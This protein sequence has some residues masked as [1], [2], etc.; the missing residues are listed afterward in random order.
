MKV[1][2]ACSWGE[3]PSSLL[4]KYKKQ[5][6]GNSGVWGSITSTE[7]HFDSDFIVFLGSRPRTIPGSNKIIQFRREPDFIE[8]YCSIPNSYKN[9]DYD[10]LGYHVSTWFLEKSFDELEEM[11]YP[12][13]IKKISSIS[14]SKWE[15]RNSILNLVSK[16]MLPGQID[17][18]GRN[19][20]SV[21]GTLNYKGQLNYNKKCKF[22]GL[23]GY[24]YSIAIENSSQKNYFTE[25]IIDCFLS[26]T[27]PIYWGC[28]NISNYFPEDS[29]YL[30]KD[31]EDVLEI[32]KRPVEKRNIKALREARDLVLNKYN[33]W[34]TI[35]HIIS[36]DYR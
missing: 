11:E 31:P 1:S 18:Y 30:I 6:P 14:S 21:V 15:H 22:N 13:K 35:S 33:L 17:F 4:K 28:P 23:A 8:K 10:N 12:K 32:I 26:W 34:P 27:I 3:S 9:F 24:E 2:F 20:D 19:L 25:K 7:N 5:T 16:M 29:F 36:G